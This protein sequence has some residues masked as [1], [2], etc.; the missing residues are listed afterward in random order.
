MPHGVVTGVHRRALRVD[1]GDVRRTVYPSLG[2]SSYVLLVGQVVTGPAAAGRPY[3]TTGIP[4]VT[5][6]SWPCSGVTDAAG[7]RGGPVNG[8]APISAHRT[9]RSPR[10][11]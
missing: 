6:T 3:S 5:V 11:C 10:A 8:P 1:M 2:Y 9:T 7:A 4:A